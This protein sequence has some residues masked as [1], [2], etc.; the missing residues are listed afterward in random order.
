[1][2]GNALSQIPRQECRPVLAVSVAESPRGFLMKTI[3][4]KGESTDKYMSTLVEL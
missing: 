4:G 2:S 1:M 3:Q